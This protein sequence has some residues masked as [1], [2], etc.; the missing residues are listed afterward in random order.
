[1]K[2]EL[3]YTNKVRINGK[4]IPVNELSQKQ[5]QELANQVGKKMFEALGYIVEETV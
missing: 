5:R 2:K 1:M 4:D 3:T